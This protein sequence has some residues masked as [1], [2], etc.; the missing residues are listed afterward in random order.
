MLT[1]DLTYLGRGLHE[2]LIAYVA[3]QEGYFEEE[4]VHVAIRDGIKWETELCAAARRSV[5]AEPCCRD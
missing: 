3:D 2:E 1:I 5:W 4:G